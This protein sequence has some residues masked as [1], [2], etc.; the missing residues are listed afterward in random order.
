[1]Y[2]ARLES[3][4]NE[5]TIRDLKA[6]AEAANVKIVEVPPQINRGDR[7]LQDEIEIG[8]AQAPG[9]RLPVVLDSPR[10]RQLDEFAELM[11]LGAD[12]GY[13]TKGNDEQVSSLDS[14]GNLECT[15]P[16]VGPRGEFPLGRTLLVAP[17][18]EPGVVAV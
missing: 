5:E 7:W 6:V 10:N 15:P 1:M 9:H 17:S 4:Q 3:G 11:L 14:F 18:Q 8:Y 2:I 13:V 16:H 12:F